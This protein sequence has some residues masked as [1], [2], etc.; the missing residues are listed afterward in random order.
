MKVLL[1][2][3]P[4]IEKL[5]LYKVLGLKAPPLG[6]A[7]IAAVL[8][9]AG[10]RVKIIDSPTEGIDI[11]TFINEVK[12]WQP[13]VVGLTAITPTIY[14]AYDAAKAIKEY[15]KDI[16][17]IIGGPHA[18]FMYEEALNNNVDV[19]VRGRVNTQPLN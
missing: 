9:R 8:E 1:A 4:G 2:I 13:D 6:L 10:H 5:E 11:K 12:A 19:V 3:P 16:P 15:D 7:W 14:K 17:I 18:T